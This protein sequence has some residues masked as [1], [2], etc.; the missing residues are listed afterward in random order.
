MKNTIT[1]LIDSLERLN[2]RL[3]LAD[4]RIIKLGDRSL[5]IM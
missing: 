1:E 3:D 2:N 4:E 5:E